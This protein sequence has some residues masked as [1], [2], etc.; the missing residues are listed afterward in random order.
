MFASF[1]RYLKKK[2][3]FS[4]MTDKEFER[5]R[6]GNKANA[7]VALSEE[8]VNCFMRNNF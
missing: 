5:A 7:L 3:G 4:I 2:N 8:E 1:E 6:K